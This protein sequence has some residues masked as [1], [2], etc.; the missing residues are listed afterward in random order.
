MIALLRTYL[1]PYAAQLAVVLVLLLI[2]ALGS[3]YLPDLNGEIID[4][5]IAKGDTAYIVRVG[6][7]MLLVTAL[8]GVASVARGLSAAPASRWASA[9]TCARRSSRRSRRSRR[10]RSTTSGRR[11]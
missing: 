9:G 4:N 5:G 8:L 2:G 10:S 7:L 3:L 1:R 11:R 6:G